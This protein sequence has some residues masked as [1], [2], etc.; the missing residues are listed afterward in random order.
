VDPTL[1]QI[2]AFGFNFAPRGW[3][4]CAGQILSIA[5][6]T[7]LFSLLGTMYG[8]NGQTTFGL[9]DL[10]GRSLVG[11][12]Q[13]PGLSNITQGEVAGTET[14]TLLITQMPA[15]NHTA[16]ATSKLQ[17]AT[18][19]GDKA[20]PQGRMLGAVQNLY[21]TPPQGGGTYVAMYDEAVLTTVAIGPAGGSQPVPVRNPY[22]G[23][24]IC[25]ATQGIFP[26]RN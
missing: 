23:M 24:N 7:A 3:A 22:L 11:M 4:M 21:Y 14:V 25:I 10:R 18:A 17:G 2:Q 13:G 1:G 5:Q 9:P 12:G 15:H 16:T 26:S 19:L 20:N 6:N 8:G